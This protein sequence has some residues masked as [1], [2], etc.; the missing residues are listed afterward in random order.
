MIRSPNLP[1]SGIPTFRGE[2]AAMFEV[3]RDAPSRR[4]V[5]VNLGI[6]SDDGSRGLQL[7]EGAQVLDGE[8]N[9]LVARRRVCAVIIPVLRYHGCAS[10]SSYLVSSIC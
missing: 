6:D 8:R 5:S 4:K 10:H 7:R 3:L 2:R 9:N 1:L